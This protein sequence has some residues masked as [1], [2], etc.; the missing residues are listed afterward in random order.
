MVEAA[1]DSEDAAGE[2]EGPAK[3]SPAEAPPAKT[4]TMRWRLPRPVKI[5]VGRDDF[6][7]LATL[8]A[9][10][11]ATASCIAAFGQERAMFLT[12]LYQSQVQATTSLQ[13]ATNNYTSTVNDFVVAAYDFEVEGKGQFKDLKPLLDKAEADYTAMSNADDALCE[14]VPADYTAFSEGLE[15]ASWDDHAGSRGMYMQIEAA[16]RH[17]LATAQFERLRLELIE[18]GLN[19]GQAGAIVSCA[20]HYLG[21]GKTIPPGAFRACDARYR[22][23]ENEG[24]PPSKQPKPPKFVEGWRC[25]PD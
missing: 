14:V 22:A 10:V 8:L 3:A 9:A 16:P 19:G 11:A 5:H 15:Q 1:K 4:S 17:K 20:H 2:Q 7:L 18:H 24:V 25:G 12:N 23:A 6:L 21:R 13:S